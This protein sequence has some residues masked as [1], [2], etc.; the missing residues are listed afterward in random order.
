MYVAGWLAAA[1]LIMLG[2]KWA[3]AI[4]KAVYNGRSRKRERQ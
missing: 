2:E 3:K 4:C 1:P